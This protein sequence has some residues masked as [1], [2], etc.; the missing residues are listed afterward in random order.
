MSPNPL[1]VKFSTK[2]LPLKIVAR[3]FGLLLLHISGN[4][5]KENNRPKGDKSPNLVT[6]WPA[7]VMAQVLHMK[8][9]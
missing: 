1:F 9:C 7:Q 8:A 5:P 6:L 4:L 3:I 2:V